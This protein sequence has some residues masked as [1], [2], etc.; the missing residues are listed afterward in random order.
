MLTFSGKTISILFIGLVFG[1]AAGLLRRKLLPSNI[2]VSQKA[3]DCTKSLK[4]SDGF[5]CE[6]DSVWE[7]RIEVLRRRALRQCGD[8]NLCCLPAALKRSARWWYP[9]CFE[10]EWSCLIERL[11]QVGDGGKYVCNIEHVRQKA[12]ESKQPCLVYSVGSRGDYSFEHAIRKR[13]PQCEIFT[14]DPTVNKTRSPPP[15][16]AKFLPWGIAGSDD[17]DPASLFGS[18]A[19]ED[20]KLYKLRTMMRLLGHTDREI[21]IFK[22][23]VEGSEYKVF[24]DL[25]A[26]DYFPFRQILIELHEP[27]FSGPLHAYLRR[28]GFVITHRE[29][30]Y[31]NHLSLHEYSFLRLARTIFSDRVPL[32]AV[33]SLITSNTSAL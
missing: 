28:H 3:I 31:S 8:G 10:P 14:F 24:D 18:R 13:I 2:D 15:P 17:I 25:N 5:Y 6:H 4:E 23:D 32:D 7:A 1:A 9:Q 33:T 19:V 20:A 16:Y 21:D 30:N 27:R 11:G 29:P 22:I 26:D 12:Q